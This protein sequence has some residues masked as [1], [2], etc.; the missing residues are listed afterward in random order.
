MESRNACAR[1]CSAIRVGIRAITE[2]SVI[3][4]IACEK[5]FI[6]QA[7]APKLLSDR[8]PRQF[9]NPDPFLGGQA[10][11]AQVLRKDFSQFRITEVFFSRG[12]YE[13]ATA[14]HSNGIDRLS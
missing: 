7:A 3:N 13:A 2:E 6:Q 12:H 1:H 11:A 14:Q 4:R 10:C 8:I 9:H 5:P